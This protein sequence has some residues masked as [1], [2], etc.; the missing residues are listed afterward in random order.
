MTGPKVVLV[1]RFLQGLTRG[2]HLEGGLPSKGE[3]HS[4]YASF[5][6]GDCHETLGKKISSRGSLHRK[7]ISMASRARTTRKRKKKKRGEGP[8]RGAVVASAETQNSKK[9]H[10][11]RGGGLARKRP[12]SMDR[13]RKKKERNEAP[14]SKGEATRCSSLRED[15][16]STRKA[17][18]EGSAKSGLLARLAGGW[19][20]EVTAIGLRGSSLEIQHPCGEPRPEGSERKGAGSGPGKPGKKGPGGGTRTRKH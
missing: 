16:R 5:R 14:Y 13:I 18:H 19:E 3:G 20:H 11:S 8:A 17:G 12:G 10:F 1:V 6:W 7:G 4:T 15:R 2:G 9:N